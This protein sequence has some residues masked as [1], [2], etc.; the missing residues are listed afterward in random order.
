MNTPDYFTGPLNLGNPTESTILE[1]AEL[2]LQLTGSKSKIQYNPLPQDDP[3]Q[4]QPDITLAKQ[5][6]EWAPTVPLQEG[7]QKTIDYFDDLLGEG[8]DKY[9][10]RW[11]MLNVKVVTINDSIKSVAP[12]PEIQTST[13]MSPS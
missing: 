7:L 1:L 5:V 8:I 9:N 3:R 10:S 4:R 6:L 12:H 2:I 13:L 11:E